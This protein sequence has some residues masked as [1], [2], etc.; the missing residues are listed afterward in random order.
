MAVND[1]T[2]MKMDGMESAYSIQHHEV[3]PRVSVT[4]PL[5]VVA[6]SGASGIRYGVRLVETLLRGGANVRLTISPTAVVVLRQEM[7]VSITLDHFEPGQIPMLRT[8]QNLNTVGALYYD[9][10]DDFSA[11]AAS[12]SYHTDGMVICPCS[13][14]SLG[15]IASGAGRDLSHR[16]AEVH[17]KEHRPLI[18]VPRETPLSLIALRNMVTLSEAGAVIL[19]ASPGFYGSQTTVATMIDFVVGRVCDQLHFPNTLAPRWSMDRPTD[20]NE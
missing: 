17:L 15:A 12:G 4:R 6:W 5:F 19:P 11:P 10:F 13:L 2:H 8:I 20:G 7:R 16:M 9:H 18:L 14:S 3:E 1:I